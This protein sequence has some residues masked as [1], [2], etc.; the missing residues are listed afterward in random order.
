[1]KL[2]NSKLHWVVNNIQEHESTA[3]NALW[4][5]LK[6][7]SDFEVVHVE[8]DGFNKEDVVAG[9]KDFYQFIKKLYE[10]IF[11]NPE[12]YAVSSEEYEKYIKSINVFKDIAE[13]NHVDEKVNVKEG[14]L[15]LAFISS[16]HFFPDFL[17][18][19]GLASE[20]IHKNDYAII[21]SKSKYDAIL[22]KL[23]TANIRKENNQRLQAL[24]DM[25]ISITETKEKYILMC[26]KYTKMFLGLRVLCAAPENDFKYTNYLRLTY[27]GFNGITP[28]IEDIKMTLTKEHSGILSAILKSLDN[29]KM[30]VKIYPL[31]SITPNHKWKVEYILNSKRVLEFYA[32][33][34]YL[35]LHIFFKDTEVL[36]E[37]IKILYEDAPDLFYWL[38]DKFKEKLCSC[39]R[40]TSVMFGD[41]KKRICGS[42]NQVEIVNPNEN[43]AKNCIALMEA[44][45]Q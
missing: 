24:F 30:K 39:P 43:D 42:T 11:T 5:C 21:V 34:A 16:I 38:D 10:N 12:K 26:K 6:M 31:N 19:L 41:K 23:D 13:N 15:R 29:P 8:V 4:H 44:I 36:T 25:G 33:P 20:G 1:M 32:G 27:K 14:K 2:V 28:Q 37:T 45:G 22:K 40:N 3:K 7:L 35:C 9:E 17:Y 18:M